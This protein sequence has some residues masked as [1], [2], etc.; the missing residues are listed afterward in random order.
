M[1]LYHFDL[2]PARPKIDEN[3]NFFFLI[4]SIKNTILYDSFLF[5]LAYYS[6]I[7]RKRYLFLKILDNFIIL[8]NFFNV[9]PGSIP[10]TVHGF[11]KWILIRPNDTYPTGS[12]STTLQKSI[13][14]C[15]S[16]YVFNFQIKV[17]FIHLTLAPLPN[18]TCPHNALETLLCTPGEGNQLVNC[19]PGKGTQQ[20]NCTPGKT[21]GEH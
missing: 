11:M 14:L 7:N 1:D 12:G 9:L 16:S 13:M 20:V 18:T 8:V 10:D 19:T 15:T 5:L 6:Y 17:K 3:S 2:D 21:N 4:F